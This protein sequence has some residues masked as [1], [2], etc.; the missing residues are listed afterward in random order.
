MF[1][2]RELKLL[3][4]HIP[5]KKV[6]IH[7]IWNEN[8]KE[9]EL[10]KIFEKLG[11]NRFLNEIPTLATLVIFGEYIGYLFTMNNKPQVIE[12]QNKFIA[13]ENRAYFS[14]LWKIAKS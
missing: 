7:A 2:E 1:L 11:E 8:F 4:K 13:E 14:Y 6:K 10:L 5:L 9:T 3:I 12:I